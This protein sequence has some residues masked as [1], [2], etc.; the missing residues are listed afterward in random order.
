MKA[1]LTS[2]RAKF[3]ATIGPFSASQVAAG[4]G[5]MLM[6]SSCTG[7]RP[8]PPVTIAPQPLPP[9]SVTPTAKSEPLDWHDAPLNAGAWRWEAGNGVSRARF[10]TPEQMVAEIACHAGTINI[11]LPHK[12]AVEPTL[13]ALSTATKSWQATAQAGASGYSVALDARDRV[14]DALAFTRGRFALELGGVGM[15]VLPADPAISRVVED[16]R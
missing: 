9:A 14:W 13:F 8:L 1:N 7:P 11:L 10:G 3:F 5:A 15:V 2:A 4:T 6:L 12:A 16:C